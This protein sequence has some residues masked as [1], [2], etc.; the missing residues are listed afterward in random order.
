M[1]VLKCFFYFL[2]ESLN[3]CGALKVCLVNRLVS[4]NPKKLGEDTKLI[5]PLNLH[6]LDYIS[7]RQILITL[8]RGDVKMFKRYFL[9]SGI[10]RN[11]IKEIFKK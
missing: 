10:K 4:N 8:L 5:G 6:L 2:L 1:F 7:K 11:D 3:F 9:T